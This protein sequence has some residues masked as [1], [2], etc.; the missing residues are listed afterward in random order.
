M[1][2]SI[3]RM[4]LLRM[5]ILLLRMGGGKLLVRC[6]LLTLLIL[7]EMRRVELLLN[8]MVRLRSDM[9]MTLIF[10]QSSHLI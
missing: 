8:T 1:K 9:C 2:L 7:D 5:R 6:H 3:V 4:L 10:L